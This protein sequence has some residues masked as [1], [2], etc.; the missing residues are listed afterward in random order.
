MPKKPRHLTVSDALRQAAEQSGQSIYALAKGSG[1]S[2]AVVWRFVKGERTL[3][4]AAID[5]LAGHLR[6]ELT[7]RTD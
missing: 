7:R 5:K 3:S 2:Y 4:Q 1:L 6:L